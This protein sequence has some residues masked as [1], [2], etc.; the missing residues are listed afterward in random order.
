[1][2][3]NRIHPK[4]SCGICAAFPRSVENLDA[5]GVARRTI[6][7]S[8]WEAQEVQQ[9]IV[10]SILPIRTVSN[11]PPHESFYVP[12]VLFEKFE[13]VPGTTKPSWPTKWPSSETQYG[14]LT[15]PVIR[16]LA[17]LP[18]FEKANQIRRIV[19]V[20][21]ANA[22]RRDDPVTGPAAQDPPG[23]HAE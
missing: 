16:Q 22:N 6:F 13:E 20:V 5:V 11:A 18:R 4:K 7:G 8:G 14:S 1:V 19:H 15:G 17:D 21:F 3:I 9:Q 12:W 23:A 10:L 2:R